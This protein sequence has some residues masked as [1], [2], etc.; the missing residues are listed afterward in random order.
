MSSIP[1]SSFVCALCMSVAVAGCGDSGESSDT[2]GE[3]GSASTS[4][5]SPAANSSGSG[6]API[7]KTA[8]EGSFAGQPLDL[9]T[10]KYTLTFEGD[11]IS[12]TFVAPNCPQ[13][14]STLH[15]SDGKAP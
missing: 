7:T 9:I 2:G 8:S 13:S 5:T 15:C 14:A 10:G 4:G 12:G 3:G 1:H 11:T 6:T